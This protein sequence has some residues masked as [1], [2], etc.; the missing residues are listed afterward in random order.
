MKTKKCLTCWTRIN[1]Q[2]WKTED[3]KKW[4]IKCRWT[5]KNIGEWCRWV[6]MTTG[7]DIRIQWTFIKK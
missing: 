1:Q 5:I 2:E 4:C 3:E 7:R 6:E